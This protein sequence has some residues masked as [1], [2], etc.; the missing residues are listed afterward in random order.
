MRYKTM[1][2]RHVVPLLPIFGDWRGTGTPVLNLVSRNGQLMSLSLYDSGSNYNTTIAAQSGSGKSFLTNEIIS[3]TLSMGGRVWVIDVGRSYEKLSELLDGDFI[4]FGKGTDA[5]LN[6]FELVKEYEDEEDVLVGLVA[7]MM[8]PTD[9]LD[10]LQTQWLKRGMREVW[11]ARRTTMTVDDLA[12][13]FLGQDDVR[14]R[15]MGA[16]LYSFTAKGQYGR[17]FNGQNNISFGNRFT[18]LELEELKGRK[19]LQQVV[20]L[21]LIYQIQ[22]EMYLGERDRP[23]VVIIDEAWD[24]LMQGDVARF[25][26]HGYRRFRKY[27]GAAVTITQGVA[28]LYNAPTGRA[29]VENSANMYL[30]G[31][32]PEAIDA[33]RKENRLPLSEGGY[34]LLK[35]VHTVPGSY[36][37]IFCITDYGAGIGRLI[38]DPFRQLIYS[39][40]ADEVTAI[41][42]KTAQGRTVR[43]AVYELIEERKRAAESAAA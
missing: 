25:I 4:H 22:Q 6:P 33:L 18:V 26:E 24:L 15:D 14:M 3:S 27:G 35:T 31:Q 1:A 28:D 37:E 32:K 17:Y 36:S 43:E 42:R 7:A 12:N 30:L 9:H 8:A 11:E 41:K 39:T 19:H 34:E 38:V 10:D 5:C 16:Q 20:L 21:Q 40:K 13:W 23:K 29:I 2:T